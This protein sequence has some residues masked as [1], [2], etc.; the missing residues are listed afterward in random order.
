MS[1]EQQGGPGDEAGR[2]EGRILGVELNKDEAVP[3]GT[4]A[5]GFGLELAEEGLFELEHAEDVVGGDQRSGGGGGGIGDKDVFEFVGA[6]GQDGGTPVD[7]GGIEQVKDGKMLNG[8]DFVHSFEAEAAFAVK[9]V[10]DMSL[11]ESSLL[12]EM[13]SG[14]FS[15]CDTFPENFTEIILQ[16]FELHCGEYSKGGTAFGARLP[17]LGFRLPGPSVIR[18]TVESQHSAW[19]RD[20]KLK[21]W[22]LEIFFGFIF[23]WKRHGGERRNNVQ[24][25]GYVGLRRTGVG[26]M[27]AKKFCTGDRCSFNLDRKFPQT[28]GWRHLRGR[29]APRTKQ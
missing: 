13:E 11:L 7:L 16:N 25:V 2:H 5:L 1:V 29:C 24:I 23:A 19:L 10:G 28:L 20:T 9:E 12:S 26:A 14:E 3:G 27:R 22:R 15:C 6:G 4:V 18:R 21:M 17:A 8:E